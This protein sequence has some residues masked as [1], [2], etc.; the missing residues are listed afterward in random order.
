MIKIE[1]PERKPLIKTENGKELI[2]CA[3]RKSWMVLT[4]EEWV[5]QNLLIY[6]VDVMRYPASLMAVE[7]QLKLGDLKK[8][9]DIVLYKNELPFLLIECKEMNVAISAKTLEQV[10]RYN[11]N[12]R[13]AHFLITNGTDCFGFTNEDG[14]VTQLDA[15]PVF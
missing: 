2:L 7:K 3:I 8:R 9:F 5:R 15:F 12:L 6:L 1:Y 11:I 14:R 4:P 13:A 10:L